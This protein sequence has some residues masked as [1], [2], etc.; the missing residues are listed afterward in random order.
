L[1]FSHYPTLK[2]LCGRELGTDD[3][4]ANISLGD[5]VDV[6]IGF[7]R[8]QPERIV[9]PEKFAIFA[10]ISH[11]LLGIGVS[12]F[13]RNVLLHEPRL[14]CFIIHRCPQVTA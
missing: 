5:Y 7:G 12:Q 13:L 14:T 10:V 1:E 8:F 3:E 11:S 9:H 4:A 6:I 2:L